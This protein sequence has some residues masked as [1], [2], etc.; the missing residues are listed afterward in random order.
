MPSY[1][2][3][4]N[5]TQSCLYKLKKSN[6]PEKYDVKIVNRK[7]D[8]NHKILYKIHWVGWKTRYD[9]WVDESVIGNH[10]L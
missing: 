2:Y 1:K 4:L 6:K 9:L 3:D 10:E 8:H 7:I 5:Q